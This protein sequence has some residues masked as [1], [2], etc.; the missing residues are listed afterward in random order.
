MSQLISLTVYK[1]NT[2]IPVGGTATVAFDVDD[3][4]APIRFNS[5]TSKA[6]FTARTMKNSVA[7]KSEHNGRVDYRSSKKVR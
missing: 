1:R 4:C 2:K 6:Y 7:G 3:I 5:S